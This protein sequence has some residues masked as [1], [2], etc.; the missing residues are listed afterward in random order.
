MAYS[1]IEEQWTNES[2]DFRDWLR[3]VAISWRREPAVKRVI[4]PTRLDRARRLGYKAKQGIVLVRVRVRRGGARKK[5]PSSG[6]RQK[7]MGSVKY[8]RAI[9]LQEMAE[10]RAERK[11]PNLRVKDS[12]HLLSDGKNHW[13]EIIL[14][15][16]DHPAQK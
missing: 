13:Y 14:R 10:H 7:A 6:R 15:D 4:R 3:R 8:S 9:S 12:Y 16:P 11:Y 5:R 2:P 1:Y